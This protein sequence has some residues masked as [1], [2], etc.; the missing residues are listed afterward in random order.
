M[1]SPLDLY[2]SYRKHKEHTLPWLSTHLSILSPGPAKTV[3]NCKPC[4]KSMLGYGHWR[5]NN[6]PLF[7]FC[8]LT[9]NIIIRLLPG[10]RKFL[11]TPL[12]KLT[13]VYWACAFHMLIKKVSVF[14]ILIKIIVYFSHIKRGTKF[15]KLSWNFFSSK[16]YALSELALNATSRAQGNVSLIANGSTE[17]AN[18]EEDFSCKIETFIVHYDL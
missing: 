7:H 17:K 11:Q 9:P 3:S 14:H 10:R 13:C 15:Y 12:V 16:I 18:T 5:P 1:A 4:N 6:L 8:A 2:H